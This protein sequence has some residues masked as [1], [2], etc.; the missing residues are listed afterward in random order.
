MNKKKRNLSREIKTIIKKNQIEILELKNTFSKIKPLLDGLER[1]ME[2]TEGR[3]SKLDERLVE[4]IQP[5]S[6][7]KKTE[8]ENRLRD[9]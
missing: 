4:I 6:N 9:L 3:V 8:N 1:R 5:K 7:E 2:I